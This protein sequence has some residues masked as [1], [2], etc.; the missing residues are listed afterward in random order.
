MANCRFCDAHLAPG[1]PSCPSCGAPIDLPRPSATSSVVD[2]VL[3]LLSAGRKVDA[4]RR[5]REAKGVSLAAAKEA[6][7]ALAQQQ[8]PGT[9]VA[10][11]P[12]AR[13][14]LSLMEGGQKI[15]AIRRYR[16]ATG[17]GL[18]DAKR[19]VET[20]AAEHGVTRQGA[21]CTS[22]LLSAITLLLTT[23]AVLKTLVT[24]AG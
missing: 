4:V 7:D 14:V 16:A 15:E 1:Q 13:E 8:H 18:A 10:D 22:V 17:S 24:M 11:D 2:E 5:Y 3:E 20:L 9:S 12:L 23:V 21:G 6:V 19:A